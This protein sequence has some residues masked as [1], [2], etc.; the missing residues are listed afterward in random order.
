MPLKYSR[1]SVVGLIAPLMLTMAVAAAGQFFRLDIGP[2]FAAGAVKTKDGLF[3]VRALACD[4]PRQ[5]R[6]MGTA[7][8]IVGGRRQSVT[9]RLHGVDTPGVFMVSRQWTEGIWVVNLTGTC[10]GRS[11][12]AAVIVPIGPKGYVKA[13]S[14][15]LDRAAT[16]SEI[17]TALKKHAG[18]LSS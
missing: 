11:A 16:A 10:P 4:E 18:Q 6:M 3:A 2:P 12:T 8:G 9:L 1:L 13:S 17:E 15:F 5:V 14:T 7:E